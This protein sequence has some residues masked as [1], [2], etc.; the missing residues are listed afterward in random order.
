MPLKKTGVLY[1]D[2]GEAVVQSSDFENYGGL[3]VLGVSVAVFSGS[4][5]MSESVIRDSTMLVVPPQFA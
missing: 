3:A 1:V 5:R 4:L 2:G